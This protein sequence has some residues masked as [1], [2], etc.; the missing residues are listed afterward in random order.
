MVE[1]L[2]NRTDLNCRAARVLSDHPRQDG[3]IPI[4]MFV[5]QERVWIKRDN[6]VG[7]IHNDAGLKDARYKDMP[8]GDRDDVAL[9]F[10]CN[11]NSTRIQGLPG[12]VVSLKDPAPAPAG[13]RRDEARAVVRE[14]MKEHC[15]RPHYCIYCGSEG[16][17]GDKCVPCGFYRG[18]HCF[19]PNGPLQKGDTYMGRK[20][21]YVSWPWQGD[22]EAPYVPAR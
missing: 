17:Y 11:M 9:F 13:D 22:P 3:R 5:G 8:D 2:K 21:A 19:P 7:P 1:G 15:P 20:L 12:R 4:E 14:M 16:L 10:H 6:L 18:S